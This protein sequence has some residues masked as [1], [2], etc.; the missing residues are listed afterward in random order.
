MSVYSFTP[1]YVGIS[2]VRCGGTEEAMSGGT[3]MHEPA[4]LLQIGITVRD[5]LC[6]I[7]CLRT[8]G[9]FSQKTG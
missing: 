5:D 3:R 7:Y 8:V 9:S 2:L 1:I 4:P 6:V